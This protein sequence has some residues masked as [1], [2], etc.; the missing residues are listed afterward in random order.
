MQ[1]WRC[2]EPSV[3]T[4]N[5]TGLP[6]NPMS[7][8]SVGWVGHNL[9]E[10]LY[11]LSKW[12]GPC[13]ESGTVQAMSSRQYALRHLV[14]RKPSAHHKIRFTSESLS[15]MLLEH[16]LVT[17]CSACEHDEYRRRDQGS[18]TGFDM[19]GNPLSHSMAQFWILLTG[20]CPFYDATGRGTP[21][22]TRSNRGR[23]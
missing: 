2:G 1:A 17:F 7:L 16:I 14:I 20:S 9:R 15:I 18:Y 23:R 12:R 6:A 4:V 19:V 10:F 3:G 22:A 21:S 8:S 5:E 13:Y 11:F